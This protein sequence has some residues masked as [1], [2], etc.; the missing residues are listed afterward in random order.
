MMQKI[1]SVLALFFIMLTVTVNAQSGAD[2]F[3]SEAQAQ[4]QRGKYGEAI[5]LLNKFISQKPQAVDG[6]TLRGLCFE[7]RNQLESAVFDFRSARKLA[8]NNSDVNKNLERATRTWYAQLNDK[9]NGHKREIAI[10]PNIPINYLEIGK[11]YKNLGEWTKAED[12]YDDYL[13]RDEASA[14]EVIRYTEILAKNNHIEKGEKILKRYVE[15]Y[16]RDHRLWSRYGYFTLWLGKKKI[17]VDAFREA[18]K[19]RPYFKEAQDGLEQALDRPYIYTYYDTTAKAREG[20]KEKPP[21]E[22][23]IDKLYRL[24]KQNPKDSETRF[25]LVD[26]LMKVNRNEEAYEQL[27]YLSGDFNGEQRFTTLWDTVSARRERGF[28]E[29]AIEY[30]NRLEKNPSDKEAAI[31]LA[32][33]YGRQLNYDSALEILKKYLD[34]KPEDSDLDVRFLYAKYAAWNYQFELSI[35]QL[36]ILLAKEPD[37][38]DYQLFR[39]QVAVWTTT[40]PELSHKY[41]DNV[42]AHDPKNLP[43]LIGKA[44]LFIRERNFDAARDKIAEANAVSPGSKEIE[45]VQNFYDVTLSQEEDRKTFEILVAGRETA[46]SGDCPGA[47]EKYDEFLS[48]TKSP[49]KIVMLEYADVNS[50]AKNFR[51]AIEVYDTLLAVEYDYDV[52]LLKAKATLWSGDSLTALSQF[53]KLVK[54]DT[55]NFD[56]KFYLA[57]TYENLHD[58]GKAKEIYDSLLITTQDTNK[59]SL[60]NKRIGWLPRSSGSDIFANFPLFTRLAPLASYYSDNQNL[61]YL[62]TGGTIE[63][64]LTSFLSVGGSFARVFLN[65]IDNSDK[66]NPDVAVSTYFTTA[67]VHLF[68]YPVKY[69]FITAGTG[70]LAYGNPDYTYTGGLRRQVYDWAIKYEREKKISLLLRNERTD[71][72]MLLYSAPLTHLR[73]GT[74]IYKFEWYYYFSP[75]VKFEGHFSY[76]TISDG[77]A[78]NDIQFRLGKKFSE[79]VTAGYEYLYTNYASDYNRKYYYSPKQFEAHSLWGEYE[80]QAD[81]DLLLTFGAKLGYVPASDFTIREVS[82]QAAYKLSNTFV[83]TGRINIGETYR[84]DSRYQY[85]SGFLSIYWSLF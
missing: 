15:K 7:K 55:S 31:Y 77:N 49:D 46:A 21:Q 2:A 32:E 22:Y 42:L 62:Y 66:N 52:A 45:T 64:G 74:S 47:L 58:Y 8:P 40:D 23:I 56:A 39:A 30:Q 35:E 17:A 5:D 83:A 81:T 43:A 80:Y 85:V 10:N 59:V 54:E 78:G 25:S 19:F 36:N 75:V 14:D 13:K 51:R 34:G 60:I 70:S 9:I 50:C 29:K 33:I 18:L 67:K 79:N 68:L 41:L 65:G 61:S 73:Y 4:M 1:L 20:I 44:T 84:D 16:P 82:C 26:E 69:L 63:L 72:V 6:Y 11:C 12:W 24:V 38:L 27:Q 71:A 57:E 37:N 48:K 76:I 28:A 53:Q 3:K